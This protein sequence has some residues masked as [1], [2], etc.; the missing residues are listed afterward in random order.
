ML[1]L[2]LH[3][4]ERQLRKWTR[5]SEENI[6]RFGGEK[7]SKIAEVIEA[8]AERFHKHPVGPVGDMLCLKDLQ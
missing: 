7:V 3:Q 1:S 8:N 6:S 5:F 2:Q 4:L